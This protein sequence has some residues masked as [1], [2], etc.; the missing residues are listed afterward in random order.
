MNEPGKK[1]R[2][3]RL[4]KHDGPAAENLFRKNELRYV[5]AA[6]RF[7]RRSARHDHIWV[8]KDKNEAQACLI[9]TRRTLF[10]A[11]FGAAGLPLPRFLNRFQAKGI[12]AIQGLREETAVLENGMSALGLDP[13]ERRDYDLMALDREPE[14][15]CFRSGPDGLILRRPV[16]ADTEA[17]FLLQS[18]YEKEEVLPMGAAFNPAA[19]RLSLQHLIDNEY[20]LAAEMGGRLVGKINTSAVSFSRRQVGGVYVHPDYRGQGVA[21]RM[22]AEFIRMLIREG[23][24]VS[25][26]VKK[27]NAAAQTVYRRIGF[28][29]V[30]DY[31]ISY[32]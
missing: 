18:G 2:W 19:C 3:K 21:R 1:G 32:Y 31:R 24:G 22:T 8:L 5:G 15:A 20:I 16:P 27:E 14:A 25:L 28:R 12:H 23:Y 29:H 10:P 26:F 30:G 4:K 13:L 11:F 6:G 17:L 9:Y 7:L